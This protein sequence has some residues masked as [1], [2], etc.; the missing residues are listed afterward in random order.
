MV[1]LRHRCLQFNPVFC[2]S[3]RSDAW[4]L[5]LLAWP[6]KIFVRLLHMLTPTES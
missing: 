4:R 3:L 2:T 5:S 1:F 6:R